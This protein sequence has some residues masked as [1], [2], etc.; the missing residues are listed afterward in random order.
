RHQVYPYAGM[1]MPARV[2]RRDALMLKQEFNCNM[3]R[4]SHYP[5][6][7]HFL[8]ACDELGIMIW[9]ETPGWGY[10][11]D[12]AFQDLVVQ[13]V[14]PDGSDLGAPA[15]DYFEPG[16]LYRD[17]SLRLVPQ[18]FLADV[19][20]KPLDVLDAASRRVEVECT[21]DAAFAVPAPVDVGV[22]LLDNGRVVSQA[23]VPVAVEQAG[24][25]TAQLSLDQLGDITLWH[26]DNPRL[27]EVV[28]TLRVN[29][30]PV[31]EF[32]R[33]IGFRDVSFETDGFFLNGNRVK[34][35][36]LNRHQVYPYTGMSMPA[37][38]Q[39]RDALM[40]KREFNCNMVRCSHYPQSPHFLDA[41]DE[42]GIMI[43]EETPGWGYLGD[44]AWQQIML[45]NVHDMVV[46]DRSRPSV[47]I[48][49][50]KPNETTHNVPALY[51]QAKE[52][53]D[54]LDG[55]RPTSGT[56]YHT[57][58][59]FVFDVMADD[60]Y[61]HSGG[62][63]TLAAPIAGVPY[64]VTEAVGALDGPPG[65]RHIDIQP[66]Q[67]AQARLHAQ[68]HNVAGGND[69]YCGLLG[70]CAFDY[71]SLAGYTFQSMKWPGVADTFRIPKPG[72]AFYQAQVSP[73]VRPV[74]APAFYWD[75]GPVSPVTSLGTQAM[76]WSNCDRLEAYLDGVHYASLTPD[77]ATYPHVAYPP[78]YLD[79]T[80]IDATT[81]PELRLDGYVGARLVLSRRFAADPA[82][83][84]LAVW[85]DDAELVADGSDVTRVGFRAVDRYGAPRPYAEGQVAI[86]VDGPGTYQG[87]V[88]G[89]KVAATPELVLPGEQTT[90]TATL[91]NSA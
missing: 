55:S 80:G 10:L 87:E 58:T 66:V 51:T 22:A 24:Q 45:Q 43:W 50:V 46:R 57:L 17:V 48:W 84:G 15:V 21:V 4:C 91:T 26:F 47:V 71:D 56:T 75:F 72:A 13:N 82:G 18:T 20:A 88:V 41:C 61:S 70:W 68:V 60:D 85:T 38:V 23:S 52:L 67:Q 28:A 90:V 31:H 83:D 19:F 8:D 89:L 65:Y 49:G 78:C 7:E 35:F 30:E 39:R 44:A 62:D 16:G 2:Q 69:A 40:L 74:I 9:E 11:G 3:V 76:I 33:R 53:A 59:D 36:G 54:S 27:Y 29:G 34:L 86:A 37:R 42:L 79:T 5:Q 81:L 32:T 12:S 6:S 25:V 77:A 73:S 64:L 14:P 1:S 63:A